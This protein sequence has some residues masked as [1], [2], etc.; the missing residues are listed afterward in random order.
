M[1]G[2]N[3][4]EQC[5]IVLP[6]APKDVDTLP[7]FE[8]WS[9]KNHGHASIILTLGV[10]GA[11]STVT[12]LAADD[13]TPSNTTALAFDYYAMTTAGG[14]TIGVRTSATSSGFATSTNDGVFYVI[15]IDA[16]AL[17]EGKPNLQLVLS[18]PAAATFG[19][20]VVVLSGARYG[21]EQSA[22]AIA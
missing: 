8:V 15:E 17:P 19:A 1:K 11:A 16:D 21:K 18:D 10:T 2:I 14:D 7:T 13:F 20:A 12:L 5:H 4:A 22:T 9:M 6:F 3:I